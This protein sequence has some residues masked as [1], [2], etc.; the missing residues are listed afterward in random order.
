MSI[1]TTDSV[2][3]DRLGTKAAVPCLPSD[4]IGDFKKI[5]AAM[6]GRSPHEIM[7]KRQ[8]ERPFKDMLTLEDYGISNGV[9][10]DLY[11]SERRAFYAN[12]SQ[13]SRHGRLAH[14]LRT[15]YREITSIL[16][17]SL[18]LYV[19]RGFYQAIPI[20]LHRRTVDSAHHAH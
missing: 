7:L 10:L 18:L 3:N 1:V 20:T 11:V 13:R 15:T 12:I 2:R 9:Q 4:T 14:D 6:I 17:S 8:S 16:F 5:V 19:E